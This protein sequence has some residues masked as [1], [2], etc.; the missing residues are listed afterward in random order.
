MKKGKGKKVPSGGP[1]KKHGPKKKMFHC[2]SS[3]MR[4]H[5]ADAGLLDKY[6]HFDS[7][8]LAAMSRG[9]RAN[10][11]ELWLEFYRLPTRKEQND[12]L[13]NLKERA[14]LINQMKK[15]K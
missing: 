11:Q 6:H 13:A 5:L 1:K 14:I 9:V 12:F 15:R 3:T 2:W 4:K 7:F 10:L 8:A